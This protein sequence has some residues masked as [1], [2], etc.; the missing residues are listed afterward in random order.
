MLDERNNGHVLVIGIID[1]Y[2]AEISFWNANIL[3]M[4]AQDKLFPP[5]C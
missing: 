3:M 4:L 5:K 2:F 1:F